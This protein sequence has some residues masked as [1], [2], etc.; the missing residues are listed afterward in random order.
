MGHS[1]YIL[2]L[3]EDGSRRKRWQR[4]LSSNSQ[5]VIVLEEATDAPAVDLVVTDGTESAA[6]DV[7]ERATV[8]V[9]G[10]GDGHGE[11]NLPIDCTD[12]ELQLACSLL[13]KI[14]RLRRQQR[15]ERRARKVLSHLAMS[16]PLTG[17]A[18][19]RA[20]DDV[21]AGNF[22]GCQTICI[23]VL[24]LDHFKRVN[25]EHGHVFGDRVLRAV[26]KRLTQCTGPDDRVARLGGDEFGLLLRDVPLSDARQ[27]VDR[28]RS[29]V[30]HGLT[31]TV[32]G[33]TLSSGFSAAPVTRL[34]DLKSMFHAAD[35]ALCHAKAAGRN[36]TLQAAPVSET[37]L[38]S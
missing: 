17:L 27:A 21:L 30:G 33:A 13:H 4:V 31:E 10:L 28:M 9:I 38:P 15:S 6:T 32:P 34:L 18:N 25:D 8:G 26:A 24:D 36:R 1:A 23:A 22:S 2:L 11:V 19:R 3:S 12:R 35:E 37:D 7:I 29:S 5:Q 14:V 16:D 20:W